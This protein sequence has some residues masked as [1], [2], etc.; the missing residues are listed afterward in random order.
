VRHNILLIIPDGELQVSG[1]NTMF[2]VIS[3]S[4]ASKFEDLG[5]KIFKNSSQIH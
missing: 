3:G 1:N 2:L 5:S 4:I